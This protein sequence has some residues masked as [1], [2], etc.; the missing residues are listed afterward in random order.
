MLLSRHGAGRAGVSGLGAATLQAAGVRALGGGLFVAAAVGALGYAQ[1]AA[2]M[3]DCKNDHAS[4]KARQACKG[5][6]A[7]QQHDAVWTAAA[8]GG[9]VILF[10]FVG[11]GLYDQRRQ[12]RG[13]GPKLG[14]VQW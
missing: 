2:N 14:D 9:A 5:Q 13:L 6:A 1:A 8:A 10:R 12:N 11:E 7:E 4:S 3:D